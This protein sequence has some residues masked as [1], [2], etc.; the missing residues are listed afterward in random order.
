[1]PSR[2]IIPYCTASLTRYDDGNDG[3]GE[4][5]VRISSLNHYGVTVQ[6]RDERDAPVE[7]TVRD[8]RISSLNHYGVTVEQR[9]ERDAPAR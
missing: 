1:M 5:G 8:I 2:S 6:Q 4:D 7:M 3:G 9:D